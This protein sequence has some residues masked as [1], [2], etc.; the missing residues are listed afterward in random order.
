[1]RYYNAR[2]GAVVNFARMAKRDRYVQLAT[3][4]VKYAMHCTVEELAAAGYLIFEEDD[5]PG[6]YAPGTHV[7]VISETSVRRT[8]PDAQPSPAL[9]AVALLQAKEGKAAL[10]LK[11]M[12]SFLSHRCCGYCDSEK[13]SWPQQTAEA[14]ALETDPDAA[15]P[16]VRAIAASRGMPVADLALRIRNNAATWMVLSGYAVGR[17]GALLDA[18]AASTTVE[19]VNAVEVSYTAPEGYESEALS[20]HL[21]G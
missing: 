19:A 2:T 14:Q 21:G 13:A 17:K 1:M 12:E 10:V 20:F 6:G 11:G 5:V 3:G 18:V 4:G 9:V 7:D 8:Y 16:L 15:A